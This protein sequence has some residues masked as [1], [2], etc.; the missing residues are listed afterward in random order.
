MNVK[1][2]CEGAAV[3]ILLLVI[4][5]ASAHSFDPPYFFI[6]PLKSTPSIVGNGVILP[7]D[8]APIS[9]DNPYDFKQP[10]SLGNAVDLALCNNKQIKT[11]WADI[12]IRA[13]MLGE[14][15]ATYLPTVT[16][17]PGWTSDWVD[18]LSSK[19]TSGNTNGF[20][21]QASATMRLF[22]FGGR[23][24]NRKAAESYLQAALSTHNATLQKALAEVIQAYFSAMTA[25]A[26]L[27]TKTDNEEIA[28]NILNSAKSKEAKGATSQSDTLRATTVLAKASLD[29]NR[30][31]GE[32]QKSLAIL[33]HVLGLP[34]K[35]DLILPQD[36][37]E[38]AEAQ[39]RELSAWLEDTQKN[40]PAVVA[41]RM[42]LEASQQQ[43]TVARSAGRPSI[44]LTG[45][46]YL[47]NRLGE[48][49]TSVSSMS[50]TLLVALSIPIFDGFASTY[51]LRG[52]E[53]QVERATSELAEVE[54]QAALDVIK[55]YADTL[56]ALRNLESSS[57]L[58]DAAKS[59]LVVSQRKYD[60]GAADIS[61]VLS[62]QAALADAWQ[63]RVR[64]LAEWHSGRLQLLASVGQMGRFAVANK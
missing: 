45:N 28:K 15:K 25:S 22:D 40:H 32:Y 54:Q 24:A 30:S 56:S 52:A 10:L 64:C 20:T 62:T 14:A 16:A 13:S 2:S 38:L 49:V 7:G 61:E 19:A 12:K 63:E 35:V 55:A 33:E 11:T 5:P 21:L 17:T 48:S 6:D 59:S 1:L 58:L 46:Y 8:S 44:N 4:W 60:K 23:T 57:V 37:N 18:Y 27:K 34:R 50:T 43:V 47:N 26:T 41:A 42:R 51:K 39:N 31:H 36:L 3:L 53:A 9:C 29:K